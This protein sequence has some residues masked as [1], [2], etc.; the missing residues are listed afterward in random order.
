VVYHQNKYATSYRN[1]C[2]R[3]MK[4]GHTGSRRRWEERKNGRLG[5]QKHITGL[6]YVLVTK[7]SN[8]AGQADMWTQ[9]GTEI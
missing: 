2:C 3:N 8:D 5:P 4:S 7:G 6:S 1:G 9:Q